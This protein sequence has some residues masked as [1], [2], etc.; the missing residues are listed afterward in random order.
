MSSRREHRRATF[1]VA[2]LRSLCY[3]FLFSGAPS[4]LLHQESFSKDLSGCR[5]VRWICCLRVVFRASRYYAA[6]SPRKGP[7][8]SPVVSK[9]G[10]RVPRA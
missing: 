6:I 4:A 9:A 8:Y 1:H 3:G 7:C 10:I 2:R 5:G